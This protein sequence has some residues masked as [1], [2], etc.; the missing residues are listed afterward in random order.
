MNRQYVFKDENTVFVSNE[1]GELKERDN[2]SN[3]DKIF[4]QENVIEEIKNHL[5]KIIIPYENKTVQKI[6]KIYYIIVTG[7]GSIVLIDNLR[8]FILDH[9][10]YIENIGKNKLDVNAILIM[11]AFQIAYVRI[12]KDRESEIF[13]KYFLNL[14]LDSEN[15]KLE[16]LYINSE[17]VRTI[18]NNIVKVNDQKQ[19]EQLRNYFKVLKHYSK[20]I[21]KQAK[22]YANG[23]WEEK[24]KEQ[25]AKDGLD[26]NAFAGYL[27]EYNTNKLTR[28]KKVS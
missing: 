15:K 19:L 28:N 3:K 6:L 20:K 4:V 7:A 14:K 13:Q 24:Q 22:I 16:E 27:N 17:P 9:Q 1:K 12:K 8:L 2:V 10:K 23:L 11:I 21:S 25:I 5:V 26:T 18:E